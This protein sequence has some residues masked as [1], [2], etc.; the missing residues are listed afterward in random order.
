MSPDFV[1]LLVEVEILRLPVVNAVVG[2][3]VGLKD[4]VVTNGLVQSATRR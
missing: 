1:S 2:I 3:D 4:V